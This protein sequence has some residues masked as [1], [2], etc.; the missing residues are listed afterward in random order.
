MRKNKIRSDWPKRITWHGTSDYVDESNLPVGSVTG[1]DEV[2]NSR[3]LLYGP[4]GR[5]LLK[6][7]T[8]WAAG[9]L[10][11]DYWRRHQK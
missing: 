5:A 8:K 1:R 10:P 3:T 9:Y 2:C 11:N 7:S 4:D 6:E